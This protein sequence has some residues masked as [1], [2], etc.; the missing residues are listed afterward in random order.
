[1]NKKLIFSI[2]IIV[3]L[4][5]YLIFVN[6]DRSSGNV[7]DIKG[8][9]VEANGIQIYDKGEKKINITMKD[10]AWLIGDEGFPAD[11]TKIDKMLKNM[12]ELRLTDYVSGGPYYEKFDLTPDKAVRVTVS[13]GVYIVIVETSYYTAREKIGVLR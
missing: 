4:L 6:S 9:D 5:G 8:W 2:G 12:M 10:G 3:V 11:K 1:M 13:S 7:P